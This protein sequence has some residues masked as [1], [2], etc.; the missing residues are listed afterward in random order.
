MNKNL[1]KNYKNLT[2][3]NLTLAR[4][5]DLMGVWTLSSFLMYF[6]YFLWENKRTSQQKLN[7]QK[8]WYIPGELDAKDI[9]TNID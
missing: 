9:I 7:Q 8:N 3:L 4:S 2:L 5:N 6:L 1:I